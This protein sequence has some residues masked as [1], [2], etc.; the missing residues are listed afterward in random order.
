MRS[1]VVVRVAGRLLAFPVEHVVET[2][3]P[4]PI[5]PAADPSGLLIGTAQIRGAPCK[6]VDLARFFE[7]IPNP[8]PSTTRF[9]VVRG[10]GEPVALRVDA[11]VAVRALDQGEPVSKSRRRSTHPGAMLPDRLLEVLAAAVWLSP[12]EGGPAASPEET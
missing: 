2:M 4:L 12:E 11:V 3:R 8:D 1:A 5:V 9:V 6:V 7:L 10:A